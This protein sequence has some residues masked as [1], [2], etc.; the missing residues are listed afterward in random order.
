MN[1]RNVQPSLSEYID[2]T[3]S[4]RETW[5]VDRHLAVCN[6][7]NRALNEMRR[8]VNLAGAAPRFEVSESFLAGLQSRLAGVEPAPARWAWVEGLRELFR[9]RVL[10]TWGAALGAVGTAALALVL[11]MPR[12]VIVP[13]EN[14]MPIAEP[15]SVQSAARQNLAL[16]A[17]DPFADLAAANLSAHVS[18]DQASDTEPTN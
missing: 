7:C 13:G 18:T 12:P 17:A 9:P 8:T 10:Q 5:E 11:F 4:A 6:E 2:N 3:L 14:R 15:A 1:C 16:Q